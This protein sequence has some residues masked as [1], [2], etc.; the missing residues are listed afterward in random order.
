MSIVAARGYLQGIDYVPHDARVHGTG[1]TRLETL[2]ARGR[3]PQV[4]AEHKI[5]DGINAAHLLFERAW[6]DE[7]RCAAGLECLRQ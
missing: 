3:K 7:T 4:V 2:I 5:E 1:K 6:F